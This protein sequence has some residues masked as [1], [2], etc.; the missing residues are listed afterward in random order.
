MTGGDQHPPRANLTRP[1]TLP[2]YLDPV[3]GAQGGP[4]SSGMLRA[5]HVC[6]A[7]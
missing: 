1:P 3:I 2:L 6:S 5:K 4:T 7:Q